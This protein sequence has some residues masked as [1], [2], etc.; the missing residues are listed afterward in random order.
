MSPSGE[1]RAGPLS[2]EAGSRKAIALDD[3]KAHLNA[4]SDSSTAQAQAVITPV[5]LAE[6]GAR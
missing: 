3:D 2:K 5:M 1:R 4:G 6:V